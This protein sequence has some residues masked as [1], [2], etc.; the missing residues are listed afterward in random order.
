MR[1]LCDAGAD[2]SDRDDAG[3]TTLIVA[4]QPGTW[5]WCGSYTMLGKTFI[6]TFNDLHVCRS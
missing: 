6:I 4:T 1:R 5:R 3:Y 2:L